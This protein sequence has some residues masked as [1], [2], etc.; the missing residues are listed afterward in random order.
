MYYPFLRGKQNELIL[1][2]GNAAFFKENYIHPIIEPVKFSSTALLKAV[3]ELVKNGVVHTLVVNPQV[4]DYSSHEIIPDDLL[5]EIM[6]DNKVTSLG[7]VLHAGSELDELT[8]FLEGKQHRNV[9]LIHYGYTN[10]KDLVKVVDGNMSIKRHV[11]IEEQTSKLYQRQFK[12]EGV[13]R[14][15]IRDG[16]RIQKKN[17]QYPPFEHFSDLHITFPDEGMDGFGDFLIVG[18]EFRDSGGPAYAVAIHLTYIDDDKDDDMFIYHFI[19]DQTDSPTNPGGKFLEALQKLV[20]EVYRPDSKIFK[21]RALGE[22]LKLFEHKHFPG[23]GYVKK[24]SMQHH[25]ELVAEYL[26]GIN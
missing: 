26:R 5:D 10:G 14:I 3:S 11:F 25:V 12:Q 2:R 13:Q 6:K 18:D 23:L 20:D 16:F 17:S 7:F 15:L 19:S 24:L 8:G 9:S 4:G 1:L 22:Y 21:S